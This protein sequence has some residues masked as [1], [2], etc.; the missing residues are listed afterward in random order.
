MVDLS[1]AVWGVAEFRSSVLTARPLT[2]DRTLVLPELARQRGARWAQILI[3]RAPLQKI[4]R[5]TE[6]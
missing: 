6:S 1:L 5:A 2:T 4:V 3:L